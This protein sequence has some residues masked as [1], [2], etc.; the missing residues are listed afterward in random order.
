M[1]GLNVLT[2]CPYCGKLIYKNIGGTNY[3]NYKG[4]TVRIESHED[5]GKFITTDY[6]YELDMVY[7]RKNGETYQNCVKYNRFFRPI[8]FRYIFENYKKDTLVEE[9][10]ENI[11]KE[12]KEQYSQ[13]YTNEEIEFY[14]NEIVSA[15]ID[16]TVKREEFDNDLFIAKLTEDVEKDLV[17]ESTVMW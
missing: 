16:L 2:R 15:V 12:I 6:S 17:Y 5:C 1:N 3:Y 11:M 13:K 10:V 7:P 9:Y 14:R 4:D 8:I